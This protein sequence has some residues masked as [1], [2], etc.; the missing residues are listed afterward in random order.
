MVQSLLNANRR[1][2]TILVLTTAFATGL[3]MLAARYGLKT[4]TGI[5][6]VLGVLLAGLGGVATSCQLAWLV[7][8]RLALT[9]SELIVRVNTL[10]AY[11]VPLDVVECFFLGQDAG[12]IQSKTADGS[13]FA[14]AIV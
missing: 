1:A 13:F 9:S 4:E 7:R 11:R 12:T 8:P 14:F 5:I 10:R 3:A 6:V 2:G